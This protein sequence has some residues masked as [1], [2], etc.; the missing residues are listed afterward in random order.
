MLDESDPLVRP[1]VNHFRQ[2]LDHRIRTLNSAKVRYRETHRWI[3]ILLT[4]LAAGNVAVLAVSQKLGDVPFWSYLAIIVGALVA[5]LTGV[6]SLLKPREKHTQNADALN[7]VYDI[8][9]RFVWRE[10]QQPP[11]T[12][13]ELNA[14]FHEFRQLEKSFFAS[15]TRITLSDD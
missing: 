14:F 12:T 3:A 6:Q 10:L 2:R 4:V 13:G 15:L 7:E 8:R 1:Q 11:M 9:A 5:V